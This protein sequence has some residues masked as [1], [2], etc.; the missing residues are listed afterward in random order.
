M[1][2]AASLGGGAHRCV[3]KWPTKHARARDLNVVIKW[4]KIEACEHLNIKS[5]FEIRVL[6]RMQQ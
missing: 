5:R 6:K 3:R 4:E 1:S 2:H